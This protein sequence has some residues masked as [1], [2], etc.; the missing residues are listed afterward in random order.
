MNKNDKLKQLIEA[1]KT[2]NQLMIKQIE[3]NNRT[4]ELIGDLIIEP[5][6]LGKAPYSDKVPSLNI[7]TMVGEPINIKP[8][9]MVSGDWYFIKYSDKNFEWIFKFDM[10]DGDYFNHKSCVAIGQEYISFSGC[11]CIEKIEYIRPATQEEVIK[12]FPHEFEIP[13]HGANDVPNIDR[14]T[15]EQL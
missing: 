8:E 10:L 11:F 13:T 6:S 7:L 5:E 14:V 2:T 3:I 15:D 1:A 9:D 12:Y 4:I